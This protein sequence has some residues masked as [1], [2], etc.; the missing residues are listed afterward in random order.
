MQEKEINYIKDQ[1]PFVTDSMLDQLAL[2]PSLYRDWNSKINVIS[3]K[4]TDNLFT[5][6]ILHSL[7]IAKIIRFKENTSILDIGT[8]GGFPGIPLAIIMPEAKFHLIDRIAKKIKVV[9]AIK[10]TLGLKN[11]IA[12]QLP[13]E[14]DKNKYDFIVSRAVTNM[15]DFMKIT[16]N[17]ILPNSFNS[18]P[19]G[20]LYLK[21]EDIEQELSALKR[22]YKIYN[23]HDFFLDDFF[24]TKRIV[25]LPLSK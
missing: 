21:G 9:N 11:V 7:S 4:D 16:K 23:I 2:L 15:A 25:Y 5:H 22:N 19:N 18:M 20:I 8:G 3:R 14:E 24:I 10:D 17:K 12:E 6:H 13:C 1:F